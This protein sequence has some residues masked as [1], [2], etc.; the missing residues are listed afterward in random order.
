[1]VCSRMTARAALSA[2][3]PSDAL[4]TWRRSSPRRAAD[5]PAAARGVAATSKESVTPDTWAEEGPRL[6]G[7]AAAFVQGLVAQRQFARSHRRPAASMWLS[8]ALPAFDRALQ[9]PESFQ[10]RYPDDGIAGGE[11]FH[12]AR[13]E[14]TDEV[15]AF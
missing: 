2:G 3:S 13:L 5:R 8:F 14:R 9:T 15:I 11:R 4:I 10:V 7:L 12:R 1:M 6:A